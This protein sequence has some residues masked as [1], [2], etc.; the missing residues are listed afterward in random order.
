MIRFI[1]LAGV[2]AVSAFAPCP[3]WAGASLGRVRN[4][5]PES[6]GARKGT[7]GT[8]VPPEGL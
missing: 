1:P 7:L 5:R 8:P 4:G 2:L 3:I 6:T